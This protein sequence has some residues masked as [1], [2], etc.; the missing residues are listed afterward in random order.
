[1]PGME[2]QAAPVLARYDNAAR[3]IFAALELGSL[4]FGALTLTEAY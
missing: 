2:R 1:M 3:D 4:V